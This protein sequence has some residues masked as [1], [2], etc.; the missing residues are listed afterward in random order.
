[1]A[2][3]NT[4]TGYGSIPIA[5]HWLM[6]L[7]IAAVYA[8]MELKSIFPKGSA[9]RDAMAAWHHQLGLCVFCLA[10]LRLLL[11]FAG[12]AP[13]IEPAPPAW[14]VVAARASHWAL[15][16]LMVGL[17]LLGW[18]TLSA[19]GASVPFFGA[20]APALIGKSDALAK[21]LR[22][23]HEAGATLGYLLIAVHAAAALHHHYLLRDNTL[24][25]MLPRR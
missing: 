16:A 6:V 12:A 10:W 3:N 14:Q 15:Y 17:P 18:L 7:L 8:A 20:E 2:W 22:K 11:R 21:W 13:V 9:Q 1:M 25:L 24:K 23:I 19:K 4:K 5:L